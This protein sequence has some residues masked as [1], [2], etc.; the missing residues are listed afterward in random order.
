MKKKTCIGLTT[1]S[2]IGVC[3][4]VGTLLIV[5]CSKLT[6][7]CIGDSITYGFGVKKTRDKDSYPVYLGQYLGKKYVVKNYGKSGATVLKKSN[8]PYEKQDEYKYSLKKKSDI[9]ILMLGTNDSKPINWNSSNDGKIYEK[10]YI[11]LIN[12][13][14]AKSKNAKFLLVQPPR[15]FRPMSPMS[16]NTVNDDLIRTTIADYIKSIGDKLDIPIISLYNF[17]KD[18]PE[19]FPDQ[20]HPNA[21]GNKKIADYI[22]KQARSCAKLW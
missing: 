4:L 20:L 11:S 5:N 19:W 18:H 2:T 7:S 22:Y 15:S 10:D 1:T 6:V 14:K 12:T 16:E 21:T 8:I 3:L 17:T 9:Y 13:Y